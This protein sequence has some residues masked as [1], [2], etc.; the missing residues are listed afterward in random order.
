MGCMLH[1]L[2]VALMVDFF[3]YMVLES[4]EGKDVMILIDA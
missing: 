3:L 4:I 2:Q 1:L